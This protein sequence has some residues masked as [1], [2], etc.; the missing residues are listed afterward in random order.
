MHVGYLRV[1]CVSCVLVWLASTSAVSPSRLPQRVFAGRENALCWIFSLF[2]M[3]TE[4]LG[5]DPNARRFQ[6]TIG[7]VGVEF[8][9]GASPVAFCCR[10]AERVGVCFWD[11]A[12]R[13]VPG[14]SAFFAGRENAKRQSFPCSMSKPRTLRRPKCTTFLGS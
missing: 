11:H 9:L 10:L 2:N 5:G 1:F 12:K 14:S 7:G 4:N 3:K 8:N 6:E 13:G